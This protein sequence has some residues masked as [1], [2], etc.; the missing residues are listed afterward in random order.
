[1]TISKKLKQLKNLDFAE[2]RLLLLC[3]FLL[4]LIALSLKAVGFQRTRLRLERYLPKKAPSVPEDEQLATAK[5]VARIVSIAA[6][7][8]PYRAN[9]LKVSLASWWLLARRGITTELKIGVNK[10]NGN[11]D[12]HAWVEY[13]GLALTDLSDPRSRFSTLI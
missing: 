6:Y 5:R 11:F 2:Q 12:A 10:E 9:C 8:G 1:M 4:P 3:L 7:N 13:H